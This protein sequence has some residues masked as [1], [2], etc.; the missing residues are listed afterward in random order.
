MHLIRATNGDV[1]APPIRFSRMLH[2]QWFACPLVHVVE[3]PINW[4][5]AAAGRDEIGNVFTC[6]INN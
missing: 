4:T 6:G 5:G 3:S 2:F 1:D